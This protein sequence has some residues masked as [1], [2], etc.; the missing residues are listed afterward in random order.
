[1]NILFLIKKKLLLKG[2]YA[3]RE[4]CVRILLVMVLNKPNHKIISLIP[5]CKKD[6]DPIEELKR[7]G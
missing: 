5:I 1:M 7:F 3:T 2:L 4:D 6:D